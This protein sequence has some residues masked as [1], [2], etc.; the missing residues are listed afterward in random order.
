MIA[1]ENKVTIIF[2]LS[3]L[4][5][6][7]GCRQTKKA[8]TVSESSVT[9]KKTTA[10]QG[11]QGQSHVFDED[12]EAFVLEEEHLNPFEPSHAQ[13]A[14]AVNDNF[15]FTIDEAESIKNQRTTVLF[16]YD[17]SKLKPEQEIIVA[18]DIE[19]KKQLVKQ[20][21]KIH[22]VGHACRWHGTK[23]YNFAKSQER[24]QE[25]AARYEHAGIP[26]SHIKVVAMGNE[27]PIV[28]ENSKAGQAP[29]RRVEIYVA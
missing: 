8:K 13:T 16:D 23:A 11:S 19:A 7:S 24:A 5:L 22:C 2:L 17:S 4:S 27:E 14:V 25:V 6:I 28:F 20:G 3:A 1:T 21:Q 29:N 9:V 26:K 18:S 12:I 10:L 15:E